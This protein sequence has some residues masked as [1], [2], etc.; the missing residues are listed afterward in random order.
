MPCELGMRYGKPD[1]AGAVRKLESAGV[2]EIVLVALYP[3]HAASTVGTSIEAVTKAL[4]AEVSLEVLPVFF[5]DPGYI[6]AQAAL[7]R[8]HLPENWDHL[9]LS[10]H[11]LPERHL[12]SADPTGSHCLASEDCCSTPSPAHAT[13]Y[14][15]QVYRTSTFAMSS[16][17]RT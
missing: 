6:Q 10:Y 3:H 17:S 15:H 1:L 12:T 14:R 16:R 7:I 9:L 13:C 4:P 8:E 11:G 5:A 2:R